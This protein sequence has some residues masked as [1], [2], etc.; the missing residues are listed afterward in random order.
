MKLPEFLEKKP[1]TDIFISDLRIASNQFRMGE[2]FRFVI[3]YSSSLDLPVNS[4]YT[5][6]QCREFVMHM[7]YPADPDTPPYEQWDRNYLFR[8]AY[9]TGPGQIGPA[10]PYVIEGDFTIPLDAGWTIPN[11]M[12]WEI[13]TGIEV[14]GRLIKQIFGITVLP[15]KLVGANP[16]GP[17]SIPG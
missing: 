17:A 12:E 7:E 2:R 5:A 10:R 13:L 15:I 6:I 8:Q 16:N 1:K 4:G 14:D 11:K 9:P 3:A